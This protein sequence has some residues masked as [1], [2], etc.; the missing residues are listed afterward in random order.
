MDYNKNATNSCLATTAVSDEDFTLCLAGLAV[1]HLLLLLLLL[2]TIRLA[3]K[4]KTRRLERRECEWNKVTEPD[5]ARLFRWWVV[6]TLHM[7]ARF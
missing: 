2:T 7:A 4:A 6:G 1:F 3:L 5:R